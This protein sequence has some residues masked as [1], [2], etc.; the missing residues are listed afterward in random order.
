MPTS[1]P[2]IISQ[3]CHLA[4]IISPYHVRSSIFIS[5]KYLHLYL[6]KVFNYPVEV[7]FHHQRVVG[8][9]CVVPWMFIVG[10]RVGREVTAC[11]WYPDQV[12]L[13]AFGA[14]VCTVGIV[15]FVN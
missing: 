7:I 5:A 1:S 6:L 10:V 4:T 13:Y 3:R 2:R 12:V 15:I 8:E 9:L 14:E 11:D